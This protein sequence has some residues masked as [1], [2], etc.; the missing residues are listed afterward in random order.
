[1]WSYRFSVVF[2]REKVVVLSCYKGYFNYIF[3]WPRT[4]DFFLCL[5][6]LALPFPFILFPDIR[7]LLCFRLHFQLI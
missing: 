4:L 6:W 7:L 5:T 3:F 1:M 2:R